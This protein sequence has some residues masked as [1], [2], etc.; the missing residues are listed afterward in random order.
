MCP[1]ERSPLSRDER[2]ER[3]FRAIAESQRR[4]ALTDEEAT[5]LAVRAVREVRAELQCGPGVPEVSRRENLAPKHVRM[6]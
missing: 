4:N 2:I 1:E 6:R 5:R 3:G